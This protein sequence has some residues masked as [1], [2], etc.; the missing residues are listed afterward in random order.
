[1]PLRGNRGLNILIEVIT[2]GDSYGRCGNNFI[3][4]KD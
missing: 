4:M 2:V 3:V 1:M